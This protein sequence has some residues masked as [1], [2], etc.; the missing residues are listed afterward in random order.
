MQDQ[1]DP[2]I[3]SYL[4]HRL[5]SYGVDPQSFL[6]QLT[7]EVEVSRQ[8][9]IILGLGEFSRAKLLSPEQHASLISDLVRRYSNETDSGIHGAAEWT[10][11]QLKA[12]DAIAKVKAAYSTGA[13]VGDRNL[14]LTKTGADKNTSLAM[15]IIHPPNEF[16]M[17]SPVHEVGRIQ[18][19][20]AKI[21][22]RHRRRIGRTFAIGGHEVTVAQFKEF[23]PRHSFDT[24]KARTSDSPANMIRGYDAAEYCNGLSE[25]E[26]IPREQ[27][28]YDPTQKFAV[29]MVLLPDYLH[30]TGYRLPSEAEWEYACR[31]GTATARYFGQ[32]DILLGE[33]AWYSKNSGNERLFLVGSLR[34]NAAGLFDMQGNAVEWCLDRPSAYG[35]AAEKVADKEEA[36]NTSGTNSRVLRGGS[37]DLIAAN[38]RSANRSFNQPD[39]EFG[40]IGFRMAR[41]YR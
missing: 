31:V 21:E 24:N 28:C 6:N 39:V 18:G 27:W 10:L 40:V 4:L 12:E 13:R 8:R 35:T 7:V 38:V 20:T 22:L 19:P 3:R 1:P 32:T 41:T 23:R 36:D 37:F 26:G 33:Y 17:G 14:Y 2:R 34:P 16:L 15:S 25:K 30:R 29:G 5:A 11:R 9:S